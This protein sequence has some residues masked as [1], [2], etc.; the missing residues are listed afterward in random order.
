MIKTVNFMLKYFT[1]VKKTSCS[2][3]LNSLRSPSKDTTSQ[4]VS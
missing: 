1:T 3:T 2:L 4:D